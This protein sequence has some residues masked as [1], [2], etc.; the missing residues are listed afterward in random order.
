MVIIPVAFVMSRITGAVGVR[1]AF[2]ITEVITSVISYIVYK[3][4]VK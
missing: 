3:K 1:N 4:N 2:W